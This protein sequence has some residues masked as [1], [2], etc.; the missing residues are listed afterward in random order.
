MPITNANDELVARAWL[1]SLGLTNV[2]TTLPQDRSS[3]SAEG[4]VQVT[5]TGDAS[6]RYFK[7][8]RPAITAVC[9]ATNPASA[10]SPHPNMQSQTPPWGKANDLAEAIVNGCYDFTPST[11]SLGVT[12]A[13]TVRTLEAVLISTPRRVSGDDGEYARYT[14]DFQLNW[15]TT[16]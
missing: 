5:I 14:V 6:H 2:G 12:G 4:F 9:W 7:L 16:G 1:R 8:R 3:W 11:L 15:N 13:P 10:N